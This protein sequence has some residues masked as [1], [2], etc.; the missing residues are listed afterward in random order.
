M[1]NFEYWKDRILEITNGGC[2]VAL[3]NCS[4]TECFGMNCLHCGFY[5]NIHCCRKMRFEWL[6]SEHEEK[7]KLTKREESCVKHWKP[8]GLLPIKTVLFIGTEIFRLKRLPCI[9]DHLL[10]IYPVP[11][12]NLTSLILKTKNRGWLKIFY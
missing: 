10:C 11:D 6:Y 1:T 2:R 5:S 12:F 8:G 9:T 3:K 7:P 4:P